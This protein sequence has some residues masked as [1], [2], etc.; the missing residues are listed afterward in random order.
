M[1]QTNA[2]PT[3]DGLFRRI[4]ARKPDALALLDPFNKPRVTGQPPRCE[5]HT[6]AASAS[7]MFAQ[8]S[9]G[10]WSASETARMTERMSN[11]CLRSGLLVSERAGRAGDYAN[12]K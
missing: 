3:L 6:T 7:R 12:E 2:S 11:G 10:A 5:S 1:T 4:L 9:S 8:R